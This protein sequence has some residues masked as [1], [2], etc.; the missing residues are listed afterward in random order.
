MNGPLRTVLSHR[1]L[2]GLLLLPMLVGGLVVWSLADRADD[3][4]QIPAAVVNLDEPVLEKGEEP[5]AA[6]RLL[7]AGLTSPRSGDRGLGWTLTDA[8]DARAGL[9]RGDYHAVITI[10]RDFSRTLA[11]STEGKRP[12]RATIAVTSTDESSALVG[13][14]SDQVARVSADRL[15]ERVTTTY[16][17]NVLSRTGKL[18]SRLGEAADGAGRLASGTEDLGSGAERLAGGVQRLAD[19][20][21]RLADGAGRLAGG[22]GRLADGAGRLEGG[23]ERLAAGLSELDRRTDPLPEQTDRLADGADRLSDGVVPYTRLLRGW[24]DACAD[25]IVAARAARLCVATE[26]AVGVDDRNARQLAE[27]SRDLARGTR[28][29]AAATP[30]LTR[31]VDRAA[32]GAQ[33]L[34][35]GVSRLAAGVRELR[36]GAVEAA[37]GATRLAGGSEE[38]AAGA[39]RLAEGSDRLQDGS[40]E[41]ADGLEDGARAVPAY[42]PEEGKELADV[43]AA[44]VTARSDR[45]PEPDGATQLAPAATAIALWLGAFATYLV[46]AAVPTRLLGRAA[47]G[48]RVAWG[49]LAPGLLV[50]GAQ[51][52]P[53]YG[54]LVALGADLGSPVAVLGVMLAAAASFAAVNQALVATLGRRRGWITSLVLATLQAVSLGGVLPLATAPDALQG[55]NAVLPMTRA[56]DGLAATALS[57]GS[58][59]PV[60]AALAVLIAWGAVAFGAST[61]ASRRAQRVDVDHLVREPA[62]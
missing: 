18:S 35:G 42:E 61:L 49:G 12:R 16:L 58:W 53:L 17:D 28:Q 23:A 26:R 3:V 8:Q 46:R 54:V 39:G 47:S 6:G 15:G 32:N 27:G 2:V 10:P 55:L 48:R 25:P 19:G 14:V 56:A 45:G 60:G 20:A 29:L 51:V 57:T 52:V 4:S 5:I 11:R 62:D 40:T 24:S 44:P 31:A 41:L 37:D 33:D 59:G 34:A 1:V 36:T 21:D 13:R 30:E 43:I 38:A 9:E 22:A 7:A 50:G